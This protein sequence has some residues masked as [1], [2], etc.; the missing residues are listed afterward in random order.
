MVGIAAAGLVVSLVGTLV[1]WQ[2][3]GEVDRTLDETLV[4]TGESLGTV[5]DTIAVADVVVADVASGLTDLDSALTNLERGLGEAEPLLGDIGELTT[6]VPDALT[7]FQRTLDGVAGAAAEVDRVLGQLESIPFAPRVAPGNSLSTQLGELSADLD[8]VVETL[9]TSSTDLGRLAETT[10]AIR[11]DITALAEDVS[12]LDQNLQD[13]SQLVG[14]YRQQAEDAGRLAESSR[15]DLD[16]SARLMRALI[17]VGG[18]LFAVSQFVP[19]WV[20]L[21]LLDESRPAR[22]TGGDQDLTSSAAPDAAGPT[23]R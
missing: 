4:I 2:L 22:P 7:E 10:A 14:Q 1:A 13:S 19:L 11:V 9:R 8:P 5:E 3:V 6:D 21:E 15:R 20:G 17:V 23:T 12:A 16:S 18:L